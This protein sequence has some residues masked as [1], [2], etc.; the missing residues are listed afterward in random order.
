MPEQI[1]T[2]MVRANKQHLCSWH[3]F[4]DGGG[5]LHNIEPGELYERT[6]NQDGGKAYT[7][8]ACAYHQ[9]AAIAAFNES[10]ETELNEN[11]L[12][13]Y[14][15]EWWSE[16]EWHA[17]RGLPYPMPFNAMATFEP[18]P[19]EPPAVEMLDASLEGEWTGRSFACP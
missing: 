15:R 2:R 17:E 7:W 9:R 16:A 3:P 6:I 13:E 5:G 12:S 10:N 14:M 19:V 8:K 18:D 11:D 4:T 1:S